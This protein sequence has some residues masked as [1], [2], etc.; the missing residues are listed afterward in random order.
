MKDNIKIQSMPIETH[1][2]DFIKQN[3]Y[4]AIDE[5]M[6][7]NSYIMRSSYYNNQST[8]GK[9]FITAPEIS[10]MFSEMV[11]LWCIDVWHKIGQPQSFYLVEFG[12]GTGSMMLHILKTAKL[13]NDF[14]N[15][16]KGIYMIEKSQ[17]LKARQQETLAKFQDIPIFHYERHLD[18]P[19]HACIFLANEFFDAL[20]IK[21]FI[22]VESMWC[23][24]VVRIDANTGILHFDRKSIHPSISTSFSKDFVNAGDGSVFEECEDGKSILRHVS[25]NIRNHNGAGL[26]I[27]Y[28]YYIPTT[29]RSYGQYVSTLQAMRNN[30]YCP[31]LED[32]GNIDISA[33]VNFYALSRITLSRN[34]KSTLTTQS[35]FLFRYDINS[36][37]RELQKMNPDIAH[38]LE[39]QKNY[40]TQ[41]MGSM[42]KVLEFHS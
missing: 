30:Q 20:P 5:L 9:D 32:I 31:I 14:Y 15:A 41:T 10:Q 8:I 21:Q 37:L 39:S 33:H 38:K 13:H 40:L 22:N 23:E 12:P 16:I 24:V 17:S 19:N 29:E 7:I 25:E 35:E 4:I 27:D 28:G 42:F 3:G 1:V 34:L 36:R 2:R 18:I 26:V 6:R 11:G